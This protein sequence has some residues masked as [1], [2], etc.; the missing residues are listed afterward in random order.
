MAGWENLTN[1]NPCTP[2]FIQTTTTLGTKALSTSLMPK[3]KRLSN[4]NLGINGITFHGA[5]FVLKGKW[6]KLGSLN[7]WGNALNSEEILLKSLQHF[8]MLRFLYF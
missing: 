5:Q 7:L 6:P 4:L 3:W 8:R 1:L 2:P